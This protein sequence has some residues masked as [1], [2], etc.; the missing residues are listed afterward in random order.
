MIIDTHLPDYTVSYTTYPRIK[1]FSL[2]SYSTS[3]FT[4][5]CKVKDKVHPSTGHEGPE[6]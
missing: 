6:A 5:V 2:F 4:Y 3:P 1:A